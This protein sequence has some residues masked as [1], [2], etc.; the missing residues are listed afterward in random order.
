MEPS[1]EDIQKACEQLKNQLDKPMS[2]QEAK[3][4]SSFDQIRAECRDDPEKREAV[5]QAWV[6]Q[7]ATREDAEEWVDDYGEL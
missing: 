5:I 3:I 1:D 6:D 4:I 7:G 2:S